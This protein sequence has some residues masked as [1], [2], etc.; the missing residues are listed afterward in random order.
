MRFAKLK[1]LTDT[2]EARPGLTYFAQR[3]EE[4]TF[5]YSLDSYKTPTVNVPVLLQEAIDQ[6]EAIEL[7]HQGVSAQSVDPIIEELA[8][9]IKGNP[10]VQS[11]LTPEREAVLAIRRDDGAER[12]ARIKILHRELSLHA[13]VRQTMSLLVEAL[14]TND[15]S[16]LELLTRDLATSLENLGMSRRH[17]HEATTE[18]F[19]N[20]ESHIKGPECIRRFFRVIFAHHHDFSLCFK[21]KNVID[22]LREDNFSSFKMT[23]TDELPDSFRQS[24]DAVSFAKCKGTEKLVVISG[25]KAFDP[26]S[27]IRKAEGRVALLQN[28]FRMYHHKESF[29]LSRR[30]A[31]EQCCAETVKVFECESSRM[32]FVN[33]D[34]PKKAAQRLDYLL[35]N[36]RLPQGEDK[37]KFF[38]V[39]EFHGMG[40]ESK[41]VENQLLNL[42]ISMETISPTRRGN[43]K[44]ENIIDAMLPIIGLNYLN[45]IVGRIT[46]DLLKWN[47]TYS[48]KLIRR[49][50]A[51]NEQENPTRVLRMLAVPSHSTLLT[52]LFEK[53]DD[54]ELLRN[55]LFLLSRTLSDASLTKQAIELHMQRV[56]WQIRRIYRVRNAIVHRGHSPSFTGMMIDNAHDYFDQVLVATSEV[57]CSINGFTNYS[58]CFGFFRWEYDAYLKRISALT[59]LDDSNVETYLW[60]RRQVAQREDILLKPTLPVME[61]PKNSQ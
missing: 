48:S 35:K 6:L 23:I 2:T 3:F 20:N 13:Y 47:R 43:N 11:V 45:R 30:V 59:A 29:D 10:V 33:D 21:T 49:V 8:T 57:S 22:A 60:E 61:G 58:E 28:L 9:R 42:W 12:L 7:G 50:D 1:G 51:N 38:S 44:V 34:R 4:L 16:R 31:V 14:P 26:Y 37:S 5:D 19:Y 15:K 40:L 17:L 54:Q 55:R 32:S 53:L 56:E 18:F 36:T 24:A 46:F 27:A 25:I 39:A 41:S 52:E